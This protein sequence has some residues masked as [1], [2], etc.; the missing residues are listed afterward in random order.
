[1]DNSAFEYD[2]EIELGSIFKKVAAQVGDGW[3]AAPCMD[4]NGNKVGEWKVTIKGGR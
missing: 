2:D 3:R 4:S 1:M